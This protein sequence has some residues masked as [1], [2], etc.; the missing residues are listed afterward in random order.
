MPNPTRWRLLVDGDSPGASNM[1]VDW[2]LVDGVACGAAPPTVRIYGWRPPCLTLGRHQGV[3]AADAGFCRRE[4]IDIVRRPTGGRALLHHLELTYAMAAPLGHDPLPRGLQ[5]AYRVLCSSLVAACGRLGVTAE[6]TGGEV[7][8]RLPGPRSVVPCFKAPA[9]GEVVVDGRK[10]VG[11]SMR[12]HR[13][14]ILQHGAVLVD[15]DPR[16]QAGSMGLPDD[17]D[18]RPHV[19]TLAEQLGA[20]PARDRIEAAIVDGIEATLGVM[21]ERGRLSPTE[22]SRAAALAPSFVVE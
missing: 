2:V 21:L 6:L 13:G 9:S 17:R 5:E 18:L 14:A 22:A 10:L 4:G 20:A 11:S 19:T 3:E 1:A 12:A 15:W 16:L 8:L 7:N